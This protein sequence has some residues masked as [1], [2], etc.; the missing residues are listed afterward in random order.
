MQSLN[1]LAQYVRNLEVQNPGI[2]EIMSSQ[3]GEPRVSVDIQVKAGEVAESVYEVVLQVRVEAKKEEKPIFSVNLNY[4]GLVKVDNAD[5]KSLE[6]TLLVHVPAFFFPFARNITA[7]ATRDCG[8]PP[9]FL[10]PVN[11]EE[12]FD[13]KKSGE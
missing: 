13:K 3:E 12:M 10:S 4:A 9:V 1:I 11:F 7:D 5:E 8:Y 2:L 6:K